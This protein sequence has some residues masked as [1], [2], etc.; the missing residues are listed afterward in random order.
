MTNAKLPDVLRLSAYKD[1]RS[2]RPDK[3][4][5]AASGMENAHFVIN[6]GPANAGLICS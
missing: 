4:F 5:Y 3:A 1:A 2:S 6:L